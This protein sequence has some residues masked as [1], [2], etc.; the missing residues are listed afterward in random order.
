[1]KNNDKISVHQIRKSFLDFFAS[2]QHTIV[3]SAPIVVKNDP[4]LFFINAGMNPF[5][6]YFLGNQPSPYKRI[7][8]TQKCLRVSGK[9][10]DLEEVGKDHYHHTM[11][12]MLGNWSFGDYFKEEAIDWAWEFLTLVWKLP[13][14]RLYAT[15][16]EGSQEE[17]VEKDNEAAQFWSKYLPADHILTGNKKDNFWEMGD[18]GPCGPCSEIHVDLR[19]DEERKKIDGKTLVN[20]EHPNVIEIWNLV[21]IQFERKQDGTLIQLPQKFVDTGMGLERLVRVINQAQSNYESDVFTTLIKKTETITCKRYTNSDTLS[22]MAFRVIADHIRTIAFTIADGQLPSNVGAGYIIRRILRRAVR[23]YYSFLDYKEPLLFQLVQTLSEQMKHAFPELNQVAYIQNIIAE[24]EKH[25]LHTLANGLK[26]FAVL[27]E[28]NNLTKSI[29]GVDAFELFD[30]YGFPLDLSNIIA[31]EQGYR[32]DEAG[33]QNALHQQRERSRTATQQEYGEWIVF[34]EGTTEFIGYDKRSTPCVINKYRPVTQKGKKYFQIVLSLTPFYAESGGQAGDVGILML[35]D[36]PT[37][38]IPIFNTVKEN[39]SILHYTELEP[40]ADIWKNNVVIATVED[41]TR[42]QHEQHHSATHL[43]HAALRKV[44]GNHVHQKGCF[45]NK[46]KIRFDCSHNQAFSQVEIQHIEQIVNQKIQ[47]NIAIEISQLPKDEALQMGAMALF[48]EK[49]G[50]VVRTVTMD[51]SFSVE[52]CGGTHVKHTGDIGLFKIVGQSA[53]A[54]GVRRI[55]AVAGKAALNW[56]QEKT[57]ELS[58]LQTLGKSGITLSDFIEQQKAEIKSLKKENEELQHKLMS[59]EVQSILATAKKQMKAFSFSCHVSHQAHSQKY[60]QTLNQLLCK[61]KD[62]ADISVL[63]ASVGAKT[64][65][66]FQHKNKDIAFDVK[67]FF[68]CHILSMQGASGGGHGT[69]WMA[70]IENTSINTLQIQSTV[71]AAL[72]NI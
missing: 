10:N 62:S 27:I 15:I 26:R 50:D 63:I 37:K 11:F 6:D 45:L 22:D 65:L 30:T 9:H 60:L 67:S 16:F 55:E 49:Y 57:T 32:I 36:T 52:L 38:Q 39:E 72:E 35:K 44:V 13:K 59:F 53:V 51:A 61:E 28:K 68:E 33:F 47:D 17:Q 23:Y 19:S 24:E 43:M 14:D 41:T 70:V 5:K 54:S 46:E 20:N 21:F 4:T 40:Q 25:F 34:Q 18:T 58:H 69:Q 8:N 29:S 71:V 56:I 3:P 12:E 31:Q 66:H 64:Y 48:G 42:S 1:M 2:K 7:A